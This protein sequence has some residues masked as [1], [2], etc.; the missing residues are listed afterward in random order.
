[1][2]RHR[3]RD[4]AACKSTTPPP[5]ALLVSVGYARNIRTSIGGIMENVAPNS[6]TLVAQLL[7]SVVY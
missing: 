1:M 6:V 4:G 7:E 2:R 3:A 5:S